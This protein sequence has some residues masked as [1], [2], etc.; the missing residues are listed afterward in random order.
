[1][2]HRVRE[3]IFEGYEFK[4]HLGAIKDLFLEEEPSVE[5]F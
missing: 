2:L 3:L 4:C 5:T 1:M